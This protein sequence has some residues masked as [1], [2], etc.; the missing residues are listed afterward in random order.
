M[1]SMFGGGNK[2]RAQ[3]AKVAEQEKRVAAQEANQARELE[4]RRRSSA[5]G[6]QSKTLF[7]QVLGTDEAIGKQTTLGG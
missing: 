5:A 7:S 4:A 2:K 1:T 3:Q 6:N